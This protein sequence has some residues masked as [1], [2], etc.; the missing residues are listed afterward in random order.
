[1]N[2]VAVYSIDYMLV[3]SHL[4]PRD[5]LSHQVNQGCQLLCI[6]IVLEEVHFAGGT[7]NENLEI[8]NIICCKYLFWL[9]VLNVEIVCKEVGVIKGIFADLPLTDQL[10]L[11]VNLVLRIKVLTTHL[12]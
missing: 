7:G 9:R 12:S 1:V 2:L 3:W 6:E 4:I 8:L 11:S 10:I 5:E